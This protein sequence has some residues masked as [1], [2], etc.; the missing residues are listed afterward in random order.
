MTKARSCRG[1]ADRGPPE[2][3][4]VGRPGA[5]RAP[6]PARWSRRSTCSASRAGCSPAP[7]RPTTSSRDRDR[8][9]D[10]PAAQRGPLDAD[11]PAGRVGHPRRRAGARRPRRLPRP[12]LVAH[13]SSSASGSWRPS[14]TLVPGLPV[15]ARHRQLDPAGGTRRLRW[16]RPSPSSPPSCSRACGRASSTSA[17]TRPARARRGS[18]AARAVRRPR[19]AAG[20]PRHPSGRPWLRRSGTHRARRREVPATVRADVTRDPARSRSK[21]RASAESVAKGAELARARAKASKSRRT[22]D[23]R[24]RPR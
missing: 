3:G 5:A 8:K 23:L 18:A 11:R 1:A 12:V 9:T 16:C 17:L 24:C 10:S 15:V 6:P 14:P 20:A 22:G 19:P 13:G 2:A 7:R 21:Q 4:A